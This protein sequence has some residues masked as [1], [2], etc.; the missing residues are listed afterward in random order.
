MFLSIGTARNLIIFFRPNTYVYY[1][2]F[3]ASVISWF[4]HMSG[5]KKI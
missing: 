1:G 4:F 3:W 2:T 5:N